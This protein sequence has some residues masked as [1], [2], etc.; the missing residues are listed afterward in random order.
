MFLTPPL[1]DV[2]RPNPL[3]RR[4]VLAGTVREE[5]I[6]LAAVDSFEGAWMAGSEG[7]VSLIRAV[8]QRQ[9]TAPPDVDLRTSY[10]RQSLGLS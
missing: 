6:D 8:D 1:S 7:V 5:S 4:A 10:L 2:P 9:M 3:I